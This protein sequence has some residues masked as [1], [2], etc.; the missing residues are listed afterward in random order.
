MKMRLAL[1]ILIL[2]TATWGF[3]QVQ[4]RGFESN[5]ANSCGESDP[6]N[7]G[8][9]SHWYSSH[10][11]PQIQDK[12]ECTNF[13]DDVHGGDHAAFIFH[14]SWNKEG[15][16][17][18]VT[19]KKDDSYNIAI[20]AK[21][22]DA[23]SKLVL[24]FANG[25][26][27]EDP[28]VSGGNPN[29]AVP[30][31]EQVVTI[32]SLTSEWTVYRFYEVVLD[33]DYD[34]IWIYALDGTILVDDFGIDKS[35]CEPYKLWQN[36]VNPPSTYVNNYIKAGVNVDPGQ[37]QGSVQITADAEPI[38]FQAGEF[39]ELL[40]GFETEVGADFTALIKPCGETPMQVSLTSTETNMGLTIPEINNWIKN[41]DSRYIVD[42]CY[43][44]GDYSYEWLDGVQ[45]STQSHITQ[46]LSRQS[47]QTIRVK[48]TDNITGDT[49]I[50]TL[51]LP[52]V[53]FYG[54]FTYDLFNVM[55][56]NGDGINDDWFVVDSTRVGSD[57]FGY[58]A[59]AYDLELFLSPGDDPFY[60]HDDE[61]RVNGFAFNE[62]TWDEDDPCGALGLDNQSDVLYGVLNLKNCSGE[63]QT[64]FSLSVICV[65]AEPARL[66][67]KN[68]GNDILLFPNPAGDKLTIVGASHLAS[69][70]IHDATGKMLFKHK[71]NGKERHEVNVSH[72]SQGIYY[73]ELTHSSG[74]ITT[75]K[76]AVSKHR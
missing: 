44:S 53:P 60:A 20:W 33:N 63:D 3:T 76:F 41:C 69:I 38:L 40:P 39:I 30:T 24:K 14:G 59:Y 1:T 31:S 29:I 7:S 19:L 9:V 13:R 34:Q 56:P 42:A 67:I 68:V 28:P 61:D 22:L 50:E 66:N 73:I 18:N 11:T 16:Y 26:V 43:G 70:S 49:V 55:T 5:S 37:T 17:Q 48:A 27:N 45:A 75:E 12:A 21:G 74:F 52:A 54:S 71:G 72:F 46:I 10:G 15:I 6:F 64:T 32:Q 57:T 2:L 25:L 47:D 23:Q 36:I 51:F 58:N 62:I 35:C 65:D 8:R 4:N